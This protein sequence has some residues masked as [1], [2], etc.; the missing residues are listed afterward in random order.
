MRRRARRAATAAAALR[1][2]GRR[3]GGEAVAFHLGPDDRIAIDRRSVRQVG[4]LPNPA[5]R[6]QIHDVL[7]VWGYVYKG[8]YRMRLVYARLPGQC[9]LMGQEILE[10]AR[11]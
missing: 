11:L 2:R 3:A 9:V 6:W 10:Y 4:T 5:A 8:R 7:Q 1:R